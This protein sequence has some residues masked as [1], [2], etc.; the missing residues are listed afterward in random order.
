MSRILVCEDERPIRELLAI[1]LKRFGYEVF[2]A[3]S[4][5]APSRYRAR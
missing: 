2:E 4:G 1:N 5:F 3:A